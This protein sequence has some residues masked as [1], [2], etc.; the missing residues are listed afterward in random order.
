MKKIVLAFIVSLVMV[1]AFR[2]YAATELEKINVDFA[3]QDA[4]MYLQNGNFI[5]SNSVIANGDTISTNSF[6][7]EGEYTTVEVKQPAF[8]QIFGALLQSQAV[9]MDAVTSAT[10]G[11]T[12]IYIAQEDSNNVDL[13][14]IVK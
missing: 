1:I 5:V 13:G 12:G 3:N 11:T 14:N 6:I 9:N 4:L 2:V 8:A 7:P 10:M